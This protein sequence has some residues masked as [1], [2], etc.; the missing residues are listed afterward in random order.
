MIHQLVLMLYFPQKYFNSYEKGKM[1]HFY[2]FTHPEFS[3]FTSK[4][5]RLTKEQVKMKSLPIICKYL[6][7]PNLTRLRRGGIVPLWGPDASG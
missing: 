3:W 1:S 5:Q 2:L 4:L 6:T 7:P